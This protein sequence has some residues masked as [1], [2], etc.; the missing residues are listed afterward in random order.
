MS[1]SKKG[2]NEPFG[3]VM[4]SMNHFFQEKPV[5]GFL[6][7][8]D[9]FF[10]NPFPSTS[11]FQV[12]VNETSD[13]HVISA[14]LPGINREQIQIDILDN[15]VTITVLSTESITEEDEKQKTI[16]K[17]QSM[18]KSIRSI[19]LPQPI[20]ENKVKASYKNGLLQIRIP[21]QKGKQITIENLD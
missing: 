13:E 19:P 6:Q 14:E 3:D 11:T 15:Y 10:K 18:R 5:R 1:E 9:E 4:K 7:S 16:K 20:D 12:N 8:M 17:Q 21:K 2:K